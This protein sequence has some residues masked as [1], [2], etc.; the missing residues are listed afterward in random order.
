[1][2]WRE[3]KHEELDVLVEEDPG[4]IVMLKQCGMWKFFQFP[5]MRAQLRLLN[6][7]VEYWHPDA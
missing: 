5:F 3:R 1:V 4:S 2:H 6:T 7:L